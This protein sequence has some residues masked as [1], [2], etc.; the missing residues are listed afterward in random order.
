M[1]DDRERIERLE[2]LE[3]LMKGLDEYEPTVRSGGGGTRRDG[4]ASD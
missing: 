4:G 2:T 3:K 1:A